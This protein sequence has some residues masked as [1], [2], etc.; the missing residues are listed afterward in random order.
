ME[1]IFANKYSFF[2]DG[3]GT[4]FKINEDNKYSLKEQCIYSRNNRINAPR[5]IPCFNQR[6]ACVVE[7]K[8]LHPDN[9]QAISNS[10]KQHIKLVS[11]AD[12]PEY[13][14]FV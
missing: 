11:L 7:L 12:L 8:I 9:F 5:I 1:I 10:D 13:R 4:F 3:M 6:L 14:F 2:D